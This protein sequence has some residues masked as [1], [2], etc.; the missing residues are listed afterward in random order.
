MKKVLCLLIFALVFAF[1][2]AAQPQM[3]APK[4][5]PPQVT[6]VEQYVDR[7]SVV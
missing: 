3:T 5:L 2:A 6:P 4:E 7:K 1:G